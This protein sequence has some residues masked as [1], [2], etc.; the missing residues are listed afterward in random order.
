[1]NGGRVGPGHDQVMRL[2][3]PA[4]VVRHPVLEAR[5]APL[6]RERNTVDYPRGH[7]RGAQQLHRRSREALLRRLA[8]EEK[9]RLVGRTGFPQPLHDEGHERCRVR[10]LLENRRDDRLRRRLL[11]LEGERR[12]RRRGLRI[13]LGRRYP[14][15]VADLRGAVERLAGRGRGKK[16]ASRG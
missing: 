8:P 1:M 9:R 13:P 16:E 6:R 11:R 14:D 4:P 3:A 12:R 5:V 7:A 2:P 10:R 15:L